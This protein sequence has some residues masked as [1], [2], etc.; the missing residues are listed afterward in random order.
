MI[1]AEN[2][3]KV[4]G[5]NMV[6][7]DVSF[8]LPS[9]EFLY[10]VGPN[11]SGKTTLVRML[12]G[13]VKPTEGTIDIHTDKI[14]YLPQR[15]VYKTDFPITVQEVI[16][17]GFACTPQLSKQD[18]RALILEWAKR[19]EI[20][21]LVDRPM[22]TLSGGQQ[23]RVYLIRALVSQPDLLV[24][25]EPTSALDPEFRR[26]F[27]DLIMEMQHKQGLTVV[28]ITHDLDEAVDP[29]SLVLFIDKTVGFFGTQH[30][31]REGHLHAHA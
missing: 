31:Y 18:K 25:D 28:Y 10:I 30:Q 23:Q 4:Y 11:G 29:E 26:K 24:L 3:S 27:N 16:E 2:L 14:G 21:A 22:G 5:E 12:V 15:M 7:H 9:G 8:F 13:L 20:E 1:R 19:M 17:G 6:L